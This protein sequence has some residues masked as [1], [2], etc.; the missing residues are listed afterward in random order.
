MKTDTI[1]RRSMKIM[2]LHL[3][4]AILAVAMVLPFTWMVLASLKRLEEIGLESWLPTVFQW[5]NYAEVFNMKGILFGRWYW[6]SIFVASWVTFL[7]VFTS[8][9]AAF[10]FSRLQWK[11][12]DAVF[13][14]YLSTMMLPG[15][16]MMIPNYQNMISLGL[17]DSYAG[18]IIP[19]AFSAFG[20][21]LMRQFMMS[22]PKSLDEAATI[23]GAS[24]WQLYWTMILPLA[25]PALVTLT[26]FTFLGNYNSMFWPLVMMNTP[27][28]YTLPIGMLAFDSSQGQQTNLLMAA[29]TMSVVPMILVFVFMQKHLVKGIMLGGVK[30]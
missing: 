23:D 20:T 19:A 9:M 22:I 7:Q 2:I 17:V 10:S 26:I 18:L 1:V 6:N 11:G 4:L 8:S 16:V 30:G 21:F 12:R 29:V 27:E 3:L 14:L 5:Q 24:K 15:L 25:R 28:R 13:L